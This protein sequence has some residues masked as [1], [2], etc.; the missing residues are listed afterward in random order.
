MSQHQPLT[1]PSADIPTTS[2]RRYTYFRSLGYSQ[3]D[4]ARLALGLD[5]MAP[6]RDDAAGAR[7]E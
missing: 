3:N 4:A 6:L 5:Q 7:R 2:G 1:S